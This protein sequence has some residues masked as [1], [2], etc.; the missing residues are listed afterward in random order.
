[1][2]IGM[3]PRADVN[4]NVDAMFAADTYSNSMNYNYFYYYK[5]V[6]DISLLFTVVFLLIKNMM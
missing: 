3:S 6:I 1:M 2:Y 5:E 4:C